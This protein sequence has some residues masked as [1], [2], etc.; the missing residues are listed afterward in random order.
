M[1]ITMLKLYILLV[2]ISLANSTSYVD[3]RINIPH[4]KKVYT[5]IMIRKKKHFFMVV[6]PL[7]N[8][9]VQTYDNIAKL[10]TDKQ[11]LYCKTS[12]FKF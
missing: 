5:G 7:Y 10:P 4:D 2:S 9:R 8:P 11:P 12:A 6:H 1:H 3:N